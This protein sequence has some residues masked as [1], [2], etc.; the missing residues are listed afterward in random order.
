MMD[1]E[2][3]FVPMP[4]TGST[5]GIPKFPA[6]PRGHQTIGALCPLCN[7]KLVV[8]DVTTLLPLGPGGDP[9]QRFKCKQGQP[10]EGIAIEVHYACATGDTGSGLEIVQGGAIQTP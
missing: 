7:E 8:G 1:G 2:L 6:K 5:P 10:Y 9:V 4:M 3:V